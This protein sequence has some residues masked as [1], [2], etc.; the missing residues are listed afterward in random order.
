MAFRLCGLKNLT[1]EEQYKVA[2]VC[3]ENDLHE[4]ALQQFL[5]LEKEIPYDG[6]MLYF[7]GVAA[8][9]SGKTE[10]AISALETLYSSTLTKRTA[11]S[12]SYI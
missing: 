2:T 7:K 6:N 1:P 12:T 10:L 11:R 3:C 9:K 4:Q 8:Y 5:A